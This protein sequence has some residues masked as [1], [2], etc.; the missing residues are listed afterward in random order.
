MPAV[1]GA[2]LTAKFLLEAAALAAFAYWGTTIGSGAV[3]VGVAIGAPLL[4]PALEL[5]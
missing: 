5:P 2:N 1:K 3:W 4:A